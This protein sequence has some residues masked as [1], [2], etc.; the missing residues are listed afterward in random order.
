MAVGRHLFERNRHLE[1][2]SLLEEGTIS[3]DVTQYD[4]TRNQE[5]PEEDIVTFSDS[6]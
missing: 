4:R 3:V 5:E 6:E 1:D 2:E